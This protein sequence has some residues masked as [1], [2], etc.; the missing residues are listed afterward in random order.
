MAAKGKKS[1]KAGANNK[2]R[3]KMRPRPSRA[4]Q[5]SVVPRVLSDIRAASWE[6]LLRDPCNAQLA[7]PCYGGADTGYLIRTVDTFTPTG[8]GVAFVSGSTIP[9]DATFQWTPYNLSA[10]TGLLYAAAASG[11]TMPPQTAFG[12]GNFIV[13][14][15]VRRYRPVASCIKFVPTGPYAARR[16]MIAANYSAGQVFFTGVPNTV[17]AAN[18]FNACQHIASLGSQAHEVRWL[19][20]AVDENFTDISVGNNTGAGSSV[21]VLREVDA[22]ATSAT[23][24]T[25]NGYLEVV[26]VWEWIPNTLSSVSIS[27]KAPTPFN[28]QQVL[29]TIGDMGAFLYDGVRAT[30]MG[31]A[32]AGVR[33]GM[34]YLTGGYGGSRTRGATM[35][36][37]T[38]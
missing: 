27:P 4:A 6:R 11:A 26:T 38:F 1:P 9:V 12:F 21:F 37:L 15:S 32:R 28:T 2:S 16:G 35:P 33:E 5:T 34:R 25:I 30:G 19:P 14:P 23:T 29:S 20:T 22:T 31:V 3:P 13:S 8:G 18:A 17:S 7:P 24:F 36:L 10:T